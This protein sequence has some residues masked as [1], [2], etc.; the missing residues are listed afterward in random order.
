MEFFYFT[1]K[2]ELQQHQTTGDINNREI[3]TMKILTLQLD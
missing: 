3:Q 2:V 1:R